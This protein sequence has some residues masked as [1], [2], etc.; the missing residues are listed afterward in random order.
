MSNECNI[1]TWVDLEQQSHDMS[2]DGTG[3]KRFQLSETIY[4]LGSAIMDQ[5]ALMMPWKDVPDKHSSA[6][7]GRKSQTTRTGSGGPTLQAANIENGP[8]DAQ[9]E[10]RLLTERSTTVLILQYFRGIP[11]GTAGR[12]RYE[13]VS[14]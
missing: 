1:A 2:R 13:R 7:M 11:D 8:L 6:F 14:N 3:I 9:R 4:A 12:Y 10:W 5:N